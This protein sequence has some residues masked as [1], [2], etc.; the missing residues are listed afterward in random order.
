MSV[1]TPSPGRTNRGCLWGC[2][3]V[4]AFVFLP[5]LLAAGYGGWFLTQGYARDPVLRGVVQLVRRDGMA[6]AVLGENIHITGIAGSAL[7]YMWGGPMWNDEAGSYVVL[8]AGDKGQGALHV[9]A[10]TQQG[11]LTVERM[12]LDGPHGDHYDLLHHTAQ[13][14]NSPTDSI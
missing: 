4:L 13:P 1:A 12:I 6:E 7:S 10:R 5:L 2:L 3:A 9:T 14:G 8:L 11:R